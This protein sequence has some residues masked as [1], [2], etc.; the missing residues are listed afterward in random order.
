MDSSAV[1]ESEKT[2]EVDWFQEL[3]NDG[4]SIDELVTC[5]LT[6]DETPAR[7]AIAVLHFRSTTQVFDR[8]KRL[9]ESER[10]R[11][12]RLGADIL[13]Q[14]GSFEK[15]PTPQFDET[16]DQLLAML[17]T[18]LH[19][20][21]LNSIAVALG[22]RH[23][24]K[25]IEPLARL[26]SHPHEDVRFGVAYSLAGFQD[27]IAINTLI[28]LT[29]DAVPIVRDWATFGLGTLNELDNPALRQALWERTDDPDD[30]TRL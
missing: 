29:R 6:D 26:K 25:S 16:V 23:A 20:S 21:V 5:A 27:S 4:R 1:D 2:A 17:S 12:R 7:T 18:E 10:F 11:E 9:C 13:A 3:R 22:H 14:F 15:E 24:P 8:A 19:E 28:E 30:N